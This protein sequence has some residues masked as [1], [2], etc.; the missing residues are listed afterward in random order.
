M[1]DEELYLRLV[2]KYALRVLEDAGNGKGAYLAQCEPGLLVF[3]NIY[4]LSRY[5]QRLPQ[6]IKDAHPKVQWGHVKAIQYALDQPLGLDHNWLWN[7][8]QQDVPQIKHAAAA[9]LAAL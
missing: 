1:T 9:A 2:E 6:A 5:T 4:A 3:E 8:V 7:V